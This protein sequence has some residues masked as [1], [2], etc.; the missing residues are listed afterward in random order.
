MKIAFIAGILGQGGAEMQ[1]FNIISLL[2]SEKI[3]VEL[4]CFEKSG[5][6]EIHTI[7]Q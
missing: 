6:W 4:F 1:L 5:F 7:F 2:K 3:D